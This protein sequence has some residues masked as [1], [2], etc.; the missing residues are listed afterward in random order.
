MLAL[1]VMVCLLATL[2]PSPAWARQAPLVAQTIQPYLDRLTEAVT[3]F[4]LENGMK[5]IVLK[6]HQAPVVSFMIH[7]NVG[8]VNEAD[9][10][11]GVAH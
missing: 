5:F 9:G 7:A 6:R 2:A 4:T 11:T 8:A 10:K 3:E 1:L